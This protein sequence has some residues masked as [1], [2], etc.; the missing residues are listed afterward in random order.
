MT[1]SLSSKIPIHL[2]VGTIAVLLSGLYCVYSATDP[3]AVPSSLYIEIAEKL[4]PY[5][6]NW[7]YSKLSF[8]DWVKSSLLIIPKVMIEDE[9]DEYKKNEFYFERYTGN[10]IL[11]VTA[12][13]TGVTD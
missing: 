10:I 5:L 1:V 7:D 13:M 2:E 3:L 9:L 4:V 12:D 6:E 8:E 11:V